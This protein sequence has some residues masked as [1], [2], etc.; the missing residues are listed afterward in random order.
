[1]RHIFPNRPRQGVFVNPP[2]WR[3][4]ASVVSDRLRKLGVDVRALGIAKE[5]SHL[6]SQTVVMVVVRSKISD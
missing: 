4:P 5:D 1:M 6:R 2:L 3:G